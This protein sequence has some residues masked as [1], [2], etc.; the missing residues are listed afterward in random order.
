MC[1]VHAATN[2]VY[3]AVS[4]VLYREGPE[5]HLGFSTQNRPFYTRTYLHTGPELNLEVS[6]LQRPVLHLE[7]SGQ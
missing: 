7:V 5:L 1:A 6:T 2:C 4:A 3:T